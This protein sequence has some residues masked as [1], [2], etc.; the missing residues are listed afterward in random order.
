[1]KYET[2]TCRCGFGIKKYET[3]KEYRFETKDVDDSIKHQLHFFNLGYEWANL[4]DINGDGTKYTDKKYL[5]LFPDTK[6]LMFSD[7]LSGDPKEIECKLL[8]PKQMKFINK[9]ISNGINE[10]YILDIEKL[11]YYEV[12]DA[13]KLNKLIKT[14]KL[15]ESFKLIV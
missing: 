14:Y 2:D 9:L 15:I 7:K 8:H 10:P 12:N 6:R 5:Y 13:D 11:G 1:M 4:T 3:M